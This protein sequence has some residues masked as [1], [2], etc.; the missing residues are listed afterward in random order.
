MPLPRQAEW[1]AH[2]DA[3]FAAAVGTAHPRAL[4][5]AAVASLPA[6]FGT[7]EL[8]MIA[9]GKA[10]FSMVE[11]LP[12]HIRARVRDGLIV[13]PEGHGSGR[14]VAGGLRDTRVLDSD[15]PLPSRRSVAAAEAALEIA[16]GC[17]RAGTPLLVLLSGGASALM[18]APAHGLEVEDIAL[19]TR[20]L[21]RSGATIDELNTIRVHCDRIKGGGLAAAASPAPTHAI[22]LSDIVSG[23]P[24]WV[25]SGPTIPNG[26]SPLDALAILRGRRAQSAC[27]AITSHLRYI[28]GHRRHSTEPSSATHAL[29]G[30]HR[31]A[32]AAAGVCARSLGFELA[33]STPGLA[34]EARD[35]A[36]AMVA[37]ARRHRARLGIQPFAVICAGETTVSVRG[38]GRGG[39]NLEAALAAA[40]MIDGDP[41]M[42]VATFATDGID[43]GSDAA[44][45]RATGLT[46]GAARRA[47]LDPEAHLAAN[48]SHTFFERAGGLLKPGPT[49]TN[50]N[51][52][53]VV[54]GY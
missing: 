33:E 31:T 14:E 5:P 44:G 16:E 53:W 7:G 21:L 12:G 34:G 17:S 40:I 13:A 15:H 37:A 9:V 29:L 32:L 30:D 10:A 18:C 47:G 4:M 49:G 36:F 42:C 41:T 6:G 24:A 51:D 20:A 48:D 3:I 35:S 46:A 50:V 25:G 39:R 54:L 43:G 11:A 8:A 2:V 45:A 23:E 38:N 19:V 1:E 27:A 26:T 22:I 28:A 52:V